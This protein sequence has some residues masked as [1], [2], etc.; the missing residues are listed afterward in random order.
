[1]N[2]DDEFI[3]QSFRESDHGVSPRGRGNAVSIE[4]NLL[5]HWHASI[6]EQDEKWLNG[7]FGELFKGRNP[8]TVCFCLVTR[9]TNSIHFSCR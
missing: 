3:Q 5:Y 8:T 6:G 1:M 2:D 4:F 9:I 7:L